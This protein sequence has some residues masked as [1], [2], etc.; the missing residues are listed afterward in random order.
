MLAKTILSIKKKYK[1]L[2]LVLGQLNDNIETEGRINNPSQ[3]YPKKSDIFSSRQV[4][5]MADNV[6]VVHRPERLGIQSYGPNN[7]PTKD[8][9]ALH[10]LKSRFQGNEGL[11]RF[12]QEFSKGTMAYPYSLTKEK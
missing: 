2:I 6:I 5:Q 4:Y 9:L 1:D 12:R 11:I 7:F 10:V 3:H 8:L